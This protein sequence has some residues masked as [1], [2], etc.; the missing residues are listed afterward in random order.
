MNATLQA[1]I[2]ECAEESGVDLEADACLSRRATFPYRG[3][4]VHVWYAENACRWEAWTY[5]MG[6]ASGDCREDAVAAI[7]AG[8]DANTI[9]ILIAERNP[10]DKA[11]R[12]PFRKV[13]C[14]A[15]LLVSRAPN[16][17]GEFLAEVRSVPPE[18]SPLGPSGGDLLGT[19]DGKTPEAA[20]EDAIFHAEYWMMDTSRKIWAEEN[21][22]P[23]MPPAHG[24]P[25]M[26]E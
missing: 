15:R 23:P 7:K 20:I 26:P 2:R 4:T 8:I 1:H 10:W 19:G 22:A 17:W 24:T 21:G 9:E 18:G 16:E 12:R 6:G 11:I 14:P 3:R 5:G 25:A 13:D